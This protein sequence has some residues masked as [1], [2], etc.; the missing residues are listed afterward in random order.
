[1]KVFMAMVLVL[2]QGDADAYPAG[3]G[4]GSGL[5][6]DEEK[7]NVESVFTVNGF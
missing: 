1:M 2:R 7:A 5:L 3:T 4:S 6:P